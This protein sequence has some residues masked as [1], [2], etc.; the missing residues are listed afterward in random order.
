[1]KALSYIHPSTGTRIKKWPGYGRSIA[2]EIKL[3]E[4]SGGTDIRVF[5]PNVGD[6]S[7]PNEQTATMAAIRGERQHQT[8][9]PDC[10]RRMEQDGGYP[11]CEHCEG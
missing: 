6:F 4:A 2:E 10:G 1:M 9:C 8:L 3:L 5:D 7:S 11:Y